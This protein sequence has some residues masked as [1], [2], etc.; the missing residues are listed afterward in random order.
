MENLGY[1]QRRLNNISYINNGGCGYAALI[2][3]EYLTRHGHNPSF[4]FLYKVDDEDDIERSTENRRVMQGDDA[5]A[6]APSHVMVL[7]NNKYYDSSGVYEYGNNIKFKGKFVQHV[8]H[9]LVK[10]AWENEST[11]AFYFD[12]EDCGKMDMALDD[13]LSKEGL[14]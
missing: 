13:I 11:W 4:V 8:T 9:E 3:H 6:F 5:E 1:L 7:F 10:K 2:L 12:R 14:S